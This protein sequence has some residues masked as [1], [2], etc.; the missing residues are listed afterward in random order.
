M[1]T[2]AKAKLRLLQIDEQRDVQGRTLLTFE[3]VID[4]TIPEDRRLFRDGS[5]LN[6]VFA[7][8]N[9]AVIARAKVGDVYVISLD[10]FDPQ[11]A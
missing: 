10:R 8:D 6:R 1:E 2:L 7:T 9:P 3:S 4:Q 5:T 11:P